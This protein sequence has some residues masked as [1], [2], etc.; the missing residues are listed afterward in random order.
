MKKQQRA[1][2]RRQAPRIRQDGKTI[3]IE[4]P[5]CHPPHP[6][7]VDIPSPCGTI[8]ELYA[9]QQLYQDVTCAL[10]GKSGGTLIKVGDQYRHAHDCSPDKRIFTTP[11]KLSKSAAFFWRL[12][13]FFQ[14]AWGRRFRKRVIEVSQ[15]GK[16][17][18]YTWDGI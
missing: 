3:V 16:V 18:G 17:V 11:P 15:Q 13:R 5:F 1:R 4:C 8:L 2:V 14:L 10:C 9:V 6:L 12:P 7:R